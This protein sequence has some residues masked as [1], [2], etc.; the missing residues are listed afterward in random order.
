MVDGKTIQGLNKIA[1]EHHKL[2][3]RNTFQTIIPCIKWLK[4][5]G[6]K[7]LLLFFVFNDSALNWLAFAECH[8]EV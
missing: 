7:E 6:Y 8:L 3:V 2:E 1:L 5:L 4:L